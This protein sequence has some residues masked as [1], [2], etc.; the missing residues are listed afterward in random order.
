MNMPIRFLVILLLVLFLAGGSVAAQEN[1]PPPVG[2]EG[3]IAAALAENPELKAATA[4]MRLYENKIIPAGSLDD[5]S[6]SFSL[7]NY[8]VDTFA[9]NEYA[10][11]GWW[12]S[13]P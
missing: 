6:L 7:S 1:N 4:R 2:L 11:S 12:R 13:S 5:P 8:P 3:L 10:M 9:G